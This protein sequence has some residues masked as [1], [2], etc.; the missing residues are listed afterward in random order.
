M[1]ILFELIIELLF[2]GAVEISRNRRISKWVRYPIAVV[3][4]LF[5]LGLLL[6]LFILGGAICKKNILAGIFVLLVALVLLCAFLV[7]GLHY[8]INREK[9]EKRK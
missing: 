1:D 3:L 6:S 2:E 4:G 8:F 7:K 5:L 9:N